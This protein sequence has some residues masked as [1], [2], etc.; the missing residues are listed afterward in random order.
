MGIS[1]THSPV[2][3]EGSSELNDAILAASLLNLLN[4]EGSEQDD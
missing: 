1:S 4:A 3:I 2:V